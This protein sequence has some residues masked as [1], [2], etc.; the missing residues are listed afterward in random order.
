MILALVE[1]YSLQAVVPAVPTVTNKLQR[2]ADVQDL[3]QQ[4]GRVSL[5][6]QSERCGGWP[7]LAGEFRTRGLP[8]PPQALSCTSPACLIARPLAWHGSEAF[9]TVSTGS[10][11]FALGVPSGAGRGFHIAA[12]TQLPSIHWSSARLCI[13]CMSQHL[14]TVLAVDLLV[15]VGLCLLVD[16]L[17]ML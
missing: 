1:L 2:W 12:F 6:E 5:D 17:T 16:A 8:S 14:G 13:C 4:G 15:A 9:L 7:H 11:D 10:S 3:C